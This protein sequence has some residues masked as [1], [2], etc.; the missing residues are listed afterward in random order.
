MQGNLTIIYKDVKY[1]NIKVRPSLEVVVTVPL[2]TESSKVDDII[3][4]RSNWI[5]KQLTY[6]NDR[7]HHVKEYVSGES[8]Q[9]LGKDYRLKIIHS[10]EERVKLSGGYLQVWVKIGTD[11][12]AKKRLVEEWLKDKAKFHFSKVLNKYSKLVGVGIDKFSIRYMKTRWGS[13]N[14][15]KSYIN[16]NIELIKKSLDLIEYVVLHELTHLVH[17]NHTAEFYDFMT[18]YMPNWKIRKNKLENT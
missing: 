15:K 2:G 4:K 14:P 11:C 6:F 13:C 18:L 1:A 8:F 5:K 7:Q 10:N 3:Q 9:F 12:D 17:Y 16:I